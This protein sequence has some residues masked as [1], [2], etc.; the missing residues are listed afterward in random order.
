MFA[1]VNIKGHQY[2]VQE[3]QKVFIPKLKDEV[4][5]KVTF[6]DVLLFSKDDNSFEIG[7]PSLDVKV[8]ATVL[9]HVKDDKVIVFKK[10]KRKGYKVR[11]GHRQNYTQITIDK[12]S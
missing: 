9:D 7:A 5:S 11:R 6:S 3:N 10:K 1:I 8:E 12:I 2:R 4:G